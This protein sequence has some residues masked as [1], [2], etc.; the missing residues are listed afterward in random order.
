MDCFQ[1]KCKILNPRTN[2]GDILGVGKSWKKKA[3]LVAYNVLALLGGD[4]AI[5]PMSCQ[6][7]FKNSQLIQKLEIYFQKINVHQR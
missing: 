5:L 7:S 4:G 3:A 2:A 1:I 6:I